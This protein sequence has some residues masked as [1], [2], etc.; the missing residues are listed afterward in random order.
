VSVSPDLVIHLNWL[1][2]AGL[3][4]ALWYLGGLVGRLDVR[5]RRAQPR[6]STSGRD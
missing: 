1:N 4:L 6:D 2:A 5:A 3:V